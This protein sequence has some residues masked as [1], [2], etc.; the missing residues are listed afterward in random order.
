MILAI[1]EINDFD[2]I[3]NQTSNFENMQFNIRS[4]ETKSNTSKI[5]A[6]TMHLILSKQKLIS[7][8]VICISF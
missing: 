3:C 8:F 1:I 7:N 2:E 6:S 4:N 5:I